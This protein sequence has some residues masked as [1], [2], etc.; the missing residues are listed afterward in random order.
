[1]KKAMDAYKSCMLQNDKAPS[2]FSSVYSKLEPKQSNKETKLK[3][4]KD[5]KT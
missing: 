5:V 1:M 2:K 4:G 3:T